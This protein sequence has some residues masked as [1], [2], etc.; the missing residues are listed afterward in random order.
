M[1]QLQFQLAWSRKVS[2]D[3]PLYAIW[4]YSLEVVYYA[5]LMSAPSRQGLNFQT[6]ELDAKVQ[7]P[8]YALSVAHTAVPVR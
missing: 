1:W 6:D 8:Q 2:P 5:I 3:H 7:R 4:E